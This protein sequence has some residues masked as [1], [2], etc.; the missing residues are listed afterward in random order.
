MNT[1][2]KILIMCVLANEIPLGSI[3]VAQ[4]SRPNIVYILADDLGYGDVRAF[5]PQNGKIQTPNLDR[6]A[7]QGMMFR[8]AHSGS[9]VCSPTRYGLLTGRYSW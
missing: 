8:D 1:Y 7:T 9:S 2:L 6:L 3:A 5:N 4:S